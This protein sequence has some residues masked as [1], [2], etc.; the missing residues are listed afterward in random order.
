MFL[1]Q[2][3]AEIGNYDNLLFDGVVSV[4][5]I[6][7]SG[8]IGIKVFTQRPLAQPFN[9]AWEGEELIYHS[10]RVPSSEPK[11]CRVSVVQTP[12][13]GGARANTRHSPGRGIVAK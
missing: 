7:Y 1:L 5:L 6:G 11:L 12:V 8:R 10:P 3:P 4:A 9:R 13:N 2:P